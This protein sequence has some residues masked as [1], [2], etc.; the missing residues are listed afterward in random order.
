VK[1]VPH[2]TTRT[3][4]YGPG[5]ELTVSTFFEDL[6]DDSLPDAPV[7]HRNKIGCTLDAPKLTTGCYD[8]L[9]AWLNTNPDH[10]EPA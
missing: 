4:T 1:V 6:V 5:Q 7:V 3:Y 8:Q 2:E 9:L 10:R